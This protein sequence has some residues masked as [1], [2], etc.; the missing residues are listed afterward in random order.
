MKL[1]R[2]KI[3]YERKKKLYG[4]GFITIWLIGAIFLFLIPMVQSLIFSFSDVKIQMATQEITQTFVG[5]KNYENMLTKDPNFVKNLT[6]VLG[7]M[8]MDTPLIMVF[9]LFIA[10]ILN[11]KFRGRTMVRAIFFLPVIVATGPVIKVINGD[12]L[13]QGITTGAKFSTLFEVNFVENIL[14]YM[15]IMNVSADFAEWLSTV[16]SDIFNLVWNCGIQ[17]LLFL[18]ALQGIPVSAKEA[19]KM[20]GATAWEFF[21]K[22]TLPYITPIILASLIYTV[23]DSFTQYDNAVMTQVQSLSQQAS[24]GPASAASWVFFIIVALCLA[25][26]ML[27]VNKF[28][29][30]EVD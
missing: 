15:G 28:V 6:T 3:S 4:Y 26:V 22:I 5:F 17:I 16:T 24:Y 27:I 1:K 30:Y 20:E 11:Q 18:A 14:E 23:V 8:L 19:A 29:Y 25:I 7:Q 13:S 10:V 21:W 9:S 12:M 2:R